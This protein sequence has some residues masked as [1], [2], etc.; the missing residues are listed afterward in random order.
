MIRSGKSILSEASSGISMFCLVCLRSS[1]LLG[2]PVEESRIPAA[3]FGEGGGT[4]AACNGGSLAGGR[5]GGGCSCSVSTGGACSGSALGMATM[6]GNTARG[7]W[8]IGSGSTEK[9]S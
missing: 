1:L 4:G 5:T 6:G 8:T 2:S 3:G 7:A 9:D